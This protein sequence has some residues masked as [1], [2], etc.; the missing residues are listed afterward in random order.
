MVGT[1]SSVPFDRPAIGMAGKGDLPPALAGD[2][3]GARRGAAQRRENLR[4]VELDVVGIE[5]RRGQ[6][7]PQILERLVAIF[8]QRAQRAAQRVAVGAE[9]QLDRLALEPFVEGLG[10]EVAGA[11]VEQ[12]RR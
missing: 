2:I 1:D 5:A 3:G 12:S 6:R 7:Q 8:R 4:A 9:I 10:I 11:F